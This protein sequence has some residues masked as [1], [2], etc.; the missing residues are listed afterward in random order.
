[1]GDDSFGN[2]VFKSERVID[3]DKVDLIDFG[4]GNDP[5]K[6]DWMEM[7]R[8]RYRIDCLDPKQPR[9]WP[10]LAKRALARSPRDR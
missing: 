10:A 1:M 6:A 8:P 4:T 7:D 5:Y 3:G 2:R 9:A